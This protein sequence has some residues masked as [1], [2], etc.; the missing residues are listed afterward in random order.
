MLLPVLAKAKSKAQGISCMNNLKQLQ[1]GWTLYSTDNNDQIVR[2]AGLDALVVFP[3][4][5]AGLPGGAK[6]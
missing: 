3:N 6:S 1:V 4:D 2:T 5:P